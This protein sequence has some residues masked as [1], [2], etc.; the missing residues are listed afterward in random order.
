MM[1]NRSLET[2]E[3]RRQAGKIGGINA[4][5]QGSAKV[6]REREKMEGYPLVLRAFLF[7]TLRVLAPLRQISSSWEAQV[8]LLDGHG[9]P[10]AG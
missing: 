6:R 9:V 8:D 7:A 10:S 3:H 2:G 5:A 4:M 1:K